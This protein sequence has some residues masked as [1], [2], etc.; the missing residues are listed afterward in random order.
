MQRG[1]GAPRESDACFQKSAPS[2]I[3][4][5][6]EQCFQTKQDENPLL[7]TGCVQRL[8]GRTHLAK[9]DVKS[10]TVVKLFT[11]VFL[12]DAY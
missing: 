4:P 10:F 9:H 12:L 6:K 7:V 11:G 1:A 5:G 3:S 8:A 2:V